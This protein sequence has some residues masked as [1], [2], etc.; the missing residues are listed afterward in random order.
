MLECME[1]IY[2][3]VEKGIKIYTVKG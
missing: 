1:I 3:A 2:M